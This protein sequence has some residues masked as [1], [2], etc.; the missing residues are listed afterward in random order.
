MPTLADAI[1][2]FVR[3]QRKKQSTTP[4]PPAQTRWEEM[5]GQ[6]CFR[7]ITEW[8]QIGNFWSSAG[9]LEPT[10]E[11]AMIAVESRKPRPTNLSITEEAGHD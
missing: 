1:A 2:T 5:R 9:G 6:T 11:N 8:D 4:P 7:T 3:P 10:R